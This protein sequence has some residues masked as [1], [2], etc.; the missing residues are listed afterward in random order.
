ML[1]LG[2]TGG[3]AAGKSLLSARFRDLGALVIDADQLAR[4]VVA[5]D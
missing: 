5:P 3:I 4:E 1:S 2:L